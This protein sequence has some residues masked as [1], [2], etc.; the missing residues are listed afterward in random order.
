M[1]Y[2][3]SFTVCKGKAFS[4]PSL[5]QTITVSFFFKEVLK[6]LKTFIPLHG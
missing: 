5:I 3:N 6:F 1:L 2:K 4:K